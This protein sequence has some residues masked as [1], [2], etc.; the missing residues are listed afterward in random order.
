MKLC[1]FE[2]NAKALKLMMDK[3]LSNTT[4]ARWKVDPKHFFNKCSNLKTYFPTNHKPLNTA[5]ISTF[6]EDKHTSYIKF[7]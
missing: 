1:Q 7:C 5:K 2:T 3:R 6:Y 4:E